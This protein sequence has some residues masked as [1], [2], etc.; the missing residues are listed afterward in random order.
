ML[1][2]GC[3]VRHDGATTRQ[4][5]KVGTKLNPGERLAPDVFAGEQAQRVL[6]H[7]CAES[8]PRL[9]EQ[10]VE[11]RAVMQAAGELPDQFTNPLGEA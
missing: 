5:C 8:A 11:L 1:L 10:L 4:Q 3:A 9:Q 2:L 6:A 7:W